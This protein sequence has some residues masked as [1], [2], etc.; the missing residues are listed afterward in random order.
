MYELST[1]K[2][3]ARRGNLNTIDSVVGHRPVSP[4]WVNT[5]MPSKSLHRPACGSPLLFGA[6]VPTLAESRK[7]TDAVPAGARPLRLQRLPS[8]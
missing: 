5:R 6:V 8:A 2:P 3:A 1:P 4:D 7:A